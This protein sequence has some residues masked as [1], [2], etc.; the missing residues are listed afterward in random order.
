MNKEL[1]AAG[2][3][4]LAAAVA[5]GIVA[6]IIRNQMSR[7]RRDL[8]SRRALRRLAALGH[9]NREA[10]SVENIRLLRDFI[11]W[12]PHPTLRERARSIL[13]RMEHD[14]ARLRL[15]SGREPA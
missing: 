14:V 5:G 6:L 8:F 2:L 1:K 7:H 9:M 15:G 12:E 13:S 10:A 3:T 11:A 4:I